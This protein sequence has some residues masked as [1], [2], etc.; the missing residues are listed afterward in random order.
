MGK[1]NLYVEQRK[2]PTPNEDMQYILEVGGKCPLCGKY[3]LKDK[4]GR[5]TK[6]FQ[7]AH[8]YPNSPTSAEAIEL[9]GVEQLGKNSEDFE[10]KIALCKECHGYYDDHKT[11]EE[12]LKLLDIKKKLLQSIEATKLL[13]DQSIED[14]IF[15]IINALANISGET[16]KLEINALKISEKLDDTYL[17][18]KKKVEMNV[19]YYFL[20]IKEQFKILDQQGKSN[21]Q[22]I[23]SQVRVAFLQ[24]EKVLNNNKDAIFKH[25]CNWLQSKVPD[26]KIEACEAVISYFI[27]NCEVF[28]EIA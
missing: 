24:A 19:I 28:H 5:S 8:I 10:N 26:S 18:L 11:R 13:S 9:N 7:I 21:F 2:K 15:S 3:L 1:E 14:D 23:A 20:F 25:L 27:Q 4:N 12:Y 22:V 6:L 16:V 17:L